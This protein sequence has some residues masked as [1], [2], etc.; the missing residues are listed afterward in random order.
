VIGDDGPIELAVPRGR[1]SSFE[2]QIVAKGQTRSRALTT[3]SSAS[4]PA[5]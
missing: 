1:N 3:G 2:P 5:G 4:T